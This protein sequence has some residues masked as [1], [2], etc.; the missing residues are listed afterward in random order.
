[1]Y[2]TRKV[3]DPKHV[4]AKMPKVQPGGEVGEDE[5]IPIEVPPQ[6]WWMDLAPPKEW[7]SEAEDPDKAAPARV[8]TPRL[9]A[10][11]PDPNTSPHHFVG[12]VGGKLTEY[13]CQNCGWRASLDPLTG[14]VVPFKFG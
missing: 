13:H 10:N 12:T 2:P 14:E 4:Q 3:P 7:D 8:G 9:C 6:I 5:E 1:M 11:S